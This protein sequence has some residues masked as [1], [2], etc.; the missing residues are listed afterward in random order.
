MSSLSH[1]DQL[2]ACFIA[3]GPRVPI[4]VGIGA[5]STK[6]C[7]DLATH[8]A[9]AGAAALMVVP[10]FYDPVNIAQLRELMADIASASRLPIM[11]YNIPS[12]SGIT[13]SPR[14]SAALSDA[15]VHYLKAHLGQRARPHGTPLR[16]LG[17]YHGV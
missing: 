8:A 7:V 15:G 5:L 3:D 12:A 1:R 9:N 6:E 11:Y 17:S 4:V 10:P 16:P 2:Q 13:L 14:E